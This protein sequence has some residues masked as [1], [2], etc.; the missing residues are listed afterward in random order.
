[1]M[2]F[3]QENERE[4]SVEELAGILEMSETEISKLLKES[5]A[6]EV[7]VKEV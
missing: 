5:G 4:P 6:S 7:N 3:E 1:M 2:A